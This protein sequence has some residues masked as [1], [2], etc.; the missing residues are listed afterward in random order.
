[1]EKISITRALTTLKTL[2][3][4]IKK[5]KG[6]PFVTYKVGGTP[7]EKIEPVKAL[8]S[9]LDLITRRNSIKRAVIESNSKTQVL[10]AGKTYTVAEAV[11]RKSSIEY[12]EMLWESMRYQLV[13]TLGT[14]E[15]I[16]ADVNR[17]LD[18]LI[19][20]S[21]GSDGASDNYDAIAKPFRD[22]NEAS[23]HD[24][25]GIEDKIAIMETSIMDF[26]SDVDIVL[27]ESNAKTFI[28]V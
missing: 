15:D 21:L 20:S 13:D 9:V 14:I 27:S 7:H 23:L 3:K 4:K 16:N 11:D 18:R 19:E 25:I 17:R 8:Q 26:N 5:A 2:D 28:E 10:I 1:M 6:L 12:D 24:A 22:R